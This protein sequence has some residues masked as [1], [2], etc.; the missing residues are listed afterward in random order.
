MYDYIVRKKSYQYLTGEF[1][2]IF[3][4]NLVQSVKIRNPFSQIMNDFYEFVD[5]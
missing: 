1:A 5:R 3:V 4:H 2:Q